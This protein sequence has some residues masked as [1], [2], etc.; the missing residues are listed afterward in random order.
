MNLEGRLLAEFPF[1]LGKSVFFLLLFSMD[2]RGRTRIMEGSQLYSEAT[3]LGIHLISEETFTE[4]SR[5]I[6][7]HIVGYH[8]LTKLT[9]QI[10]HHNTL[11][12]SWTACWNTPLLHIFYKMPPHAASALDMITVQWCHVPQKHCGYFLFR[13]ARNKLWLWRHQLTL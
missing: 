12:E 8:D 7:D 6:L 1:L 9:H 5:L 11:A 3:D 4:T 13:E 10:N 2:W